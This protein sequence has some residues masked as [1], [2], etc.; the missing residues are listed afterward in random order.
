MGGLTDEGQKFGSG[1][2]TLKVLL[3]EGCSY[4]KERYQC[5]VDIGPTLTLT[6]DGGK[7]GWVDLVRSVL[8]GLFE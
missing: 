2:Q 7:C 8:L 6:K 3:S 1:N 5:E 4:H